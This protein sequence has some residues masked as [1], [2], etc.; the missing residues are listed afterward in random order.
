M[1]E[2]K[3]KTAAYLR[4]SKGDG[5]SDCSSKG[6]SNSIS[7]QRLIIEHFLQ[8]NEDFELVETY[9]DDGYTG[10]NFDRP[11]V[12]K[13]LEDIDAGLIDCVIVKDLS[14]FGRERIET[15][16]YILKEFESKGIRF[17]AINDNY[18]SLTAGSGDKHLVMPIKAMTNDFYSQDIS[19]KVKASQSVKR[20]K[21][22]FMGAQAPFGYVKDPDN[23]NHLL[24]D[25]E[26]ANIV[27]M[28]FAKRISGMSANEI[29]EHL[30]TAGVMTPSCY[31]EAH[32][33]SYRN[34][35]TK[36]GRSNWS[37]KQ[38]L[39]VLKNETYLGS[40]VQGKTRRVSYKVNR[41]VNIPE[42]EWCIVPNMHEPIVSESDFNIVKS[43]LKRD[44]MKASGRT[45]SYLF[46]GLLFCGDCGSP[47]LRRLRRNKDGSHVS[48][49]CK[50]Y[51]NKEGCSSHKMPADD[52]EKLVTASINNMM[53]T[54]CEY[55]E[56]AANIDKIAVSKDE[57]VMQNEELASLREE[58]DKVETYRM[59]LFEDVQE[60]LISSKMYD[61]LKKQYDERINSINS[62]IE[63]RTKM[64]DKLYS[65]GLEAETFIKSFRNNPRIEK[66]D[67]V[68]L[69]TLIDRIL[70]YDNGTI[71]IVYRY[72]DEIK[73]LNQIIT[74]GRKEGD[75]HG[76][77]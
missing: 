7:N 13:M 45:G 73:T 75:E 32:D 41:R 9:V 44:T 27:R 59:G 56:L 8:D 31:K 37:A 76:Q 10:T 53:L 39:T 29:A 77:N 24:V 26:A 58:I 34:T 70:V 64:I 54:L 11:G 20:E 21:G 15:G 2:Y 48:Y 38:V 19:N 46:S 3:Y 40:V 65:K 23:P 22:E 42:E 71:E 28:I 1:N 69:A 36:P 6:E 63:E 74:T 47:M 50:G 17:I 30:K 14:R 68:L 67:R 66:L 60:G 5:D 18:D 72:S 43:L 16:M 35:S 33:P 52:L 25:P 57:A 61:R 62:S 51:T 55:S 4:L 12:Q 49:I